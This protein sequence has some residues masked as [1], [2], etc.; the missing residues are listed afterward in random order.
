MMRK[1]CMQFAMTLCASTNPR[2]RKP[3]CWSSAS[4]IGRGA[5]RTPCSTMLTH[6]ATLALVVSGAL[7][8]LTAY[9]ST[10]SQARKRPS[11]RPQRCVTSSRRLSTVSGPPRWTS[12]RSSMRARVVAEKALQK[13][14]TTTRT[15]AAIDACSAGMS[16]VATCAIVVMNCSHSVV[17]C[18]DCRNRAHATCSVITVRAMSRLSCVVSSPHAMIIDTSSRSS[19]LSLRIQKCTPSVSWRRSR[20]TMPMCTYVAWMG[21]R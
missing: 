2:R 19:T 9:Q 20:R 21:R 18:H 10:R 1:M 11:A 3:S 15:M 16:R 17:S 14:R 7:A 6:V 8:T 12:T 13:V 4:S 5:H